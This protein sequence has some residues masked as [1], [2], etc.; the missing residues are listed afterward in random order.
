LADEVHDRAAIERG[1]LRYLLRNPAA[2]DS[3]EGVR[4]WWLGEAGAVSHEMLRNVMDGLFE[5]GWLVTHGDRPE[6]R[7]YCL[8]ERESEAVK[9]FVEES[10]E[11]DG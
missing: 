2:A 1:V 11:R 10:E 8:N 6:T 9:R 5:R 4:L 7:I 3:V